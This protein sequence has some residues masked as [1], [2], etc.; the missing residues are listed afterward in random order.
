MLMNEWW[1]AALRQLPVGADL[2]KDQCM[3]KGWTDL[4]H[5]PNLLGGEAAGRGR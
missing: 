4:P 2:Q 3:L 1:L 5:L